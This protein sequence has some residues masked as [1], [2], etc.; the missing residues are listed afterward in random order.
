MEL[1]EFEGMLPDPKTGAL[2]D[3]EQREMY[4]SVIE[5]RDTLRMVGAAMA[6]FQEAA[7][8][9]PMLKMMMGNMGLK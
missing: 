6:Q 2:S 5:I 1:V 7:K 8:T 3:E 9:N 4:D